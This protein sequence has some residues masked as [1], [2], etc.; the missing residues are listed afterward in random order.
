MA[1]AAAVQREL[2]LL[3]PRLL[4]EPTLVRA[5]EVPAALFFTLVAVVAAETIGIM[6]ASVDPHAGAEAPLAALLVFP[7]EALLHGRCF[8]G[9]SRH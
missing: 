1:E 6:V 8:A 7:S 4:L 5:M 3:G 2:P 9:V